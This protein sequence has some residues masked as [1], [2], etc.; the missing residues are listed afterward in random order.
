MR[1]LQRLA[2]LVVV[3]AG[4]TTATPSTAP[5]QAPSQTA[6][7]ASLEPS[8]SPV[9]D[10]VASWTADLDALVPGMDEIHPDL[11]HGT[12]V[13]ELE[14]AVE[15]LKST[16]ETATDDEL[17]VGVLQI[18][19]M[20]SAA[21]HD[22]HTGA[23]IWGT[24]TYPVHSLPLRLWL[25]PEGVYVVAALPPFEA[26]VG[27]KVET[28][29]GHPIGDVLAALDP[30][31]P[32][33]N[34]TTVTLLTPRHLLIPEVLHGLGLT[35]EVGPVELGLATGPGL[36][37]T[38]T[39]EPVAMADYNDWAGPYGLHLP[40]DPDVLYL[41]DTE[42]VLW[43]TPI[44]G[45]GTL[46]VQY[47]RVQ[48]VA[49]SV[50]TEIQA[51]AATPGIERIVVDIR[52]NFGGETFARQQVLDLLLSD[53]FR[54]KSISVI[55]GRNTFSAASLFAGDV[56]T[57]TDAAFVGEPMGGAANLYG[58]SR[59]VRL[60]YSGIVVSV[61]SEYFESRPQ[62]GEL[63]IELDLSAPQSAA[64]YFDGRDAALDAI[65]GR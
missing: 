8:A 54:S 38:T 5:S 40:D 39:V 36:I 11:G 34:P 27:A 13:A 14:A 51:A 41:S 42:N 30:L 26:L 16:I 22:G 6:P 37:E 24:G 60:P 64:A 21:G 18:V 19:A 63:N 17:M 48:R 56:E 1:R 9:E 44:A 33:D 2:I 57:Q 15:A 62:S 3:V 25:F 35:D 52:H 65:L 45:S 20:V 49:S 29:A 12:P 10:R 46:F 7:P 28:L 61:A 47:N 59:D 31:I 4:C 32:R 58:N 55:L 53:A 23:F 43:A 50:I